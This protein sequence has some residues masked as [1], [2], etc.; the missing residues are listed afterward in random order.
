MCL[1]QLS[2]EPEMPWEGDNQC[3]LAVI[4]AHRVWWYTPIVPA[5]WREAVVG[6]YC[7]F[8]ATMV[9]RGSSKTARATQWDSIKQTKSGLPTYSKVFFAKTSI[10]IL[11]SQ[12]EKSQM[13]NRQKKTEGKIKQNPNIVHCFAF[14]SKNHIWSAASIWKKYA[15]RMTCYTVVISE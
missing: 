3:F 5:L 6:R 13:T 15:T 12:W 2:I 7:N 8:K 11:I 10:E 1:F 9:Y 4:P 14:T